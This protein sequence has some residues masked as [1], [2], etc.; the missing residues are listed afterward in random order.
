MGHKRKAQVPIEVEIPITPMLDM[1]FQ[2]PL[3]V[4]SGSGENAFES[5]K[6]STHK[7][8]IKSPATSAPWRA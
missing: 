4:K 6:S 1:A 5:H 3:Q 2:K 8:W 7:R